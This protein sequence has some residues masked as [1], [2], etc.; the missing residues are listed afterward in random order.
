MFSIIIIG[1]ILIVGLLYIILILIFTTGWFRL[2]LFNA[3]SN[4]YDIFTTVI[5]PVK[6]E[7]DNIR[8]LLQDLKKQKYPNDHFEILVINDQSSDKTADVVLKF[9]KKNPFL[10]IKLFETREGK[11]GKKNAILNGIEKSQGS[12]IVCVDGDCRVKKSWLSTLISYYV[13]NNPKMICGPVYYKP[14]KGIFQA[15]Q[16]MELL[17]LVASG[18]G[19]VKTGIPILCNGANLA[20]EKAAFYKVGGFDDNINYKSGDDVFFLHS[21]RKMYGQDAVHFLKSRGAIVKTKPSINFKTFINQR[22]RWVSKSTGYTYPWIIITALVVY[23]FNL[24]ILSTFIGGLFSPHWMSLFLIL[25]SVKIIID[26]PVLAGITAFFRQKILLF[27][28]IPFQ[29]F[30]ILFVIATGLIGNIFGFSWKEKRYN[31]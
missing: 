24:S 14:I 4:H 8:Q 23:L 16:A 17:S 21:M 3:T 31:R 22:K 19:S 12:F 18:A 6:D 9:Q 13:E 28:Y 25:I 10:G 20:Y 1:I 26:F 2:K 11:A 27:Y 15:F 5:I 29:I 30:Y 7:V